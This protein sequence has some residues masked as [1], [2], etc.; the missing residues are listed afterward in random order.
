MQ[1]GEPIA[2]SV[3]PSRGED[4]G[5]SAAWRVV[6]D[7]TQPIVR[8][9]ARCAHVTRVY[10]GEFDAN[11]WASIGAAVAGTFL[12]LQTYLVAARLS[13]DLAWRWVAT[14]APAWALDAAAALM[15]L[16]YIFVTVPEDASDSARAEARE[17]KLMAFVGLVGFAMIFATELML[18]QRADGADITFYAAAGPLYAGAAA[19]AAYGLYGLRENWP[20]NVMISEP[21][22]PLPTYI[23]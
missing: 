16:Y 1:R 4:E 23:V 6:R 22:G 9:A 15:L 14:L 2:F 10:A 21:A 17:A 18:C 5:A 7:R 20:Q 11:A 8:G 13:G 19:V 12:L 3:A